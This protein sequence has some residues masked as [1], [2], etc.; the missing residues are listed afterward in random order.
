MLSSQDGYDGLERQQMPF[1]LVALLAS[2]GCLETA[3]L[4][5]VRTLCT[6]HGSPSGC[7]AHALGP[8]M[9]QQG[10]TPQASSAGSMCS[11]GQSRL[12]LLTC[13]ACMCHAQSKL[14]NAP[15]TC[16]TSGS[17]DTVL[18]SGYASVFGLPLPLLGATLWSAT[19]HC[20]KNTYLAQHFCYALQSTAANRTSPPGC[21][22][23]HFAYD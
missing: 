11:E 17:C 6:P 12:Q 13:A 9:P 10:I 20:N 22:C 3:Y 21:T 16:P 23:V 4:T 7:L 2:A 19:F 5:L 18:N 8:S 15:V 14:L 1:G